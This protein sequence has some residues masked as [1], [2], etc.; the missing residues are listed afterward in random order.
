MAIR[1]EAGT[2]VVRNRLRRRIRAIV[3]AYQPVAGRDVVVQATREA[4]G[5]NFQELSVNLSTALGRA[6]V[7][8]TR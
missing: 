7:G 4:A 3:A 5:R 2:A 1:A 6:G 8:S